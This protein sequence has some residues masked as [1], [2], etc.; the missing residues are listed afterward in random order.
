M[1]ALAD[2][3]SRIDPSLG[4]VLIGGLVA[5]VA[6]AIVVGV[7]RQVRASLWVARQREKDRHP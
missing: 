6:V 3:G 2:A 5:Y 4:D 7:W 1:T